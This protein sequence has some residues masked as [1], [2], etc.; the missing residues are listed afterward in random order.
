MPTPQVEV[1]AVAS[2]DLKNRYFV[3]P[4]GDFCER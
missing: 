3:V 4:Y 2:S 1:R